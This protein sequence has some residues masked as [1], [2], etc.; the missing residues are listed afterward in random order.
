MTWLLVKEIEGVS[1]GNKFNDNKE[2]HEMIFLLG[3]ETHPKY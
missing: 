3:M 2:I 1:Q